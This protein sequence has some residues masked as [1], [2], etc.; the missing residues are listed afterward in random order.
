MLICT[1]A[2]GKR[3]WHGATD[4]TAMT[5]ISIVQADTNGQVVKWMEHVTDEQYLA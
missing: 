3:H 5:H 1:C 4:K 2:P